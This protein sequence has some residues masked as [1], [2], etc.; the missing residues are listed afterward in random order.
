MTHPIAIC[1]LSLLLLGGF[2]M[3]LSGGGLGHPPSSGAPSAAAP[4][5]DSTALASAST[6]LAEG[7]GPAAGHAY[8]CV[9]AAGLSDR[10]APTTSTNATAADW[11]DYPNLPYSR[12]G[13]LMAYDAADG[14]VV[15]FGGEIITPYTYM[16]QYCNETWIYSAGNW[17]NLTR[18]LHRAPP[19]GVS[20]PFIY[21]A[22]DRYLLLETSVETQVNGSWVSTSETWTFAA[23]AWTLLHPATSPGALK[24]ASATYDSGDGYVL[25]FGGSTSRTTWEFSHGNWSVLSTNG[26]PW[27]RSYAVLVDD[28]AEGYVLLSGGE[29]IISGT[30]V[31]TNDTW[32]YHAGNW[33]EASPAPSFAPPQKG[34]LIGAT[35]DP[36]SGTILVNVG[37]TYGSGVLQY[38]NGTWTTLDPCD[39]FA[40]S[41]PIVYDAVDREL[42]V[43]YG[44]DGA[45]FYEP[46][47]LSMYEF[48]NASMTVVSGPPALLPTPDYLEPGLADDVGEGNLI[49]YVD[50]GTLTFN[51]ATWAHTHSVLEPDRAQCSV[52][53]MTYDAKDGYV[54]LFCGETWEYQH[55]NWSQAAQNV[56][57]NWPANSAGPAITYDA[58]DGYVLLY[59]GASDAETWTWSGGNWTNVSSSAGTPPGPR[60]GAAMCY[61]SVDAY[62][63]L[64]GGMVP[65]PNGTELNDTWTYSG[66]VWTELHPAAVPSARSYAMM[67][68]DDPTGDAVLFGGV[69]DLMNGVYRND[70]WTF[71]GGNW[72]NRTGSIGSGPTA[73]MQGAIAYASENA[74][75]ILLGGV[76]T[77]GEDPSVWLWGVPAPPPAPVIAGF[78]ASLGTTDVNVST[79]LQVYVRD[80]AL[81]LSFNYSGLPAGCLGADSSTISCAPSDPGV[82]LVRVQ[83]S[84]ADS[85]RLNATLPLMVNPRPSISGFQVLPDNIT[86][87]ANSVLDVNWSGGT[88]PVSVA[89]TGLPQGCASRDVAALICQPNQTGNYSIQATIIDALGQSASIS[90]DLEVGNAPVSVMNLTLSRFAIGPGAV[91]LGSTVLVSTEATGGVG[92]LVFA[93]SG[94]PPGCGGGDVPEF[95]CTPAATG[96]YTVG[97]SVSDQEATVVRG[98]ALLLVTA[99]PPGPNTTVPA[100]SITSFTAA[101]S[102]FTLGGTVTLTVSATGGTSPYTYAYAGL[103]IGCVSANLSTLACAP[104]V[105]GASIVIVSVTGADGGVDQR[106]AS[107]TVLDNPTP[108]PPPP[109]TAHTSG[110]FVPIWTLYGIVGVAA[111]LL[112][113]VWWLRRR[114]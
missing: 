112:V 31:N 4:R 53:V 21:D 17:T 56:A 84:D 98:T 80:S 70:T 75:V 13:A 55:G 32:T 19:D 101:P 104:V 102:E 71:T 1:S 43:Y 83:V 37:C 59:G 11:T 54:L 57:D 72:T 34:G 60:V 46:T 114:P 106:V 7:R 40:Y 74:Q 110:I 85:R 29:A 63:L 30:Y 108:L 100:P 10:C 49:Y 93:Y 58:A 78:S 81:P 103:P 22:A 107:F 35:Y 41:G 44:Y 12:T 47:W 9:E 18:I 16:T 52:G 66:G 64:F 73:R 95:F 62:V 36:R 15:V 105:S 33:T 51:G 79:T 14:Y 96:E 76:G 27:A 89:Y 67:A 65:Y 99:I 38:S 28:P 87:G 2:T 6:S 61:D 86:L 48:A 92:T 88:A 97:V 90:A 68:F 91:V 113:V 24:G 77:N 3:P 69:G 23:D 82:F 42:L 94:L 8:S 111:T 45:D 50:G 20:G 26:S 25:L 109:A 39:S 5:A